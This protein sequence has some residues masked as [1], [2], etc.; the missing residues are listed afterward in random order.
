MHLCLY[1]L[2][3]S[4]SQRIVWL[5]EELQLDYQLIIFDEHLQATQ[6]SEHPHP[7]KKFPTLEYGVMP[8]STEVLAES[9]AIVDF[10]CQQN[11]GLG[12]ENLTQPKQLA[13]FYYWK[14]FAEASLMPNL[15]LKQIFAQIVQ[16]TPFPIRFVAQIFKSGFNRGYLNAAL[17]QQM[18]LIDQKLKT[19][20]WI[21]G[22]AFSAADILLWFPLAACIQLDPK[23]QHYEHIHAYLTQIERRPAF[24]SAVAKGQWSTSIFHSY[25]VKAN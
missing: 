14:N 24:Q 9:G 1:H 15:A 21:A 7:L 5:C 23:F 10:L 17:H 3:N 6:H 2:K 20:P 13:D 25:W 16:H 12:I 19:N 18:Q 4:R 11:A 22:S 8:Q